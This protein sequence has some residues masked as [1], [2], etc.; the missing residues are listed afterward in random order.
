M[1]RRVPI[2]VGVA[3]LMFVALLDLQ[4]FAFMYQPATERFGQYLRR[5][6]ETKSTLRTDARAPAPV[7]RDGGRTYR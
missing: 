1:P 7:S 3:A 2:K 6:V 5:V 4:L